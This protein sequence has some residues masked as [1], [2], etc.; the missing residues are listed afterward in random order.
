MA[1]YQLSS[2]ESF[3]FEIM[4]ILREDDKVSLNNM[5]SLKKM[6]KF[7]AHTKYETKLQ[8]GHI[9]AVLQ[10][11]QRSTLLHTSERPEQQALWAEF[12]AI[13]AAPNNDD[14]AAAC[15]AATKLVVGAWVDF[16]RPGTEQPYAPGELDGNRNRRR[17]CNDL[18]QNAETL[19]KRINKVG[20]IRQRQSWDYA[21][22]T[23][24][25]KLCW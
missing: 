15:E 9:Y 3:V 11:G 23:L 7:I 24:F 16:P 20:Q 12:A 10:A 25:N 4:K 22:A 8:F 19:L 18:F 21:I 5:E 2:E 13:N 17:V 1:Q 14:H 6:A